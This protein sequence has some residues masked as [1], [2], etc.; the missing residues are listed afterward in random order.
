MFWMMERST[1]SQGFVRA[2]S[3][4]RGVI[5]PSKVFPG[6]Q[7]PKKQDRANSA[8]QKRLHELHALMLS[9]CNCCVTRC[10]KWI[11]TRGR[12]MEQLLRLG[13]RV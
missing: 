3:I 7:V 1:G 11:G 10:A 6:Q 5:H 4:Y 9:D 12:G 8:I 13:G 2:M